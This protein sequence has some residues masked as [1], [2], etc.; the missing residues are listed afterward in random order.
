MPRKPSA[1]LPVATDQA[2]RAAEQAILASPLFRLALAP[3]GPVDLALG[4][5]R[6][7][8]EL[9]WMQGDFS[10]AVELATALYERQLALAA[11]ALYRDQRIQMHWDMAELR[12]FLDIQ[13]KRSLGAVSDRV[14]VIKCPPGR[15]LGS[16]R[17]L[18][19]PFTE[20]ELL[21]EF[22]L[23]VERLRK[24]YQREKT[25]RPQWTQDIAKALASGVS[26]RTVKNYLKRYP[27]LQ[28]CVDEAQGKNKG[29]RELVVSR[30]NV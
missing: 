16:E 11:V 23:V 30:A 26:G 10:R 20:A 28:Q 15:P 2:S 7:A 21:A 29:S 5:L 19:G 13:M 18:C 6:Q 1:I 17:E 22:P 3:H 4:L 25:R 9:R 12:V 27:E 24:R 8:V 14:V